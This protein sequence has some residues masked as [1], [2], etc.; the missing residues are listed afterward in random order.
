MKTAYEFF[1]LLE[2]AVFERATRETLGQTIDYAWQYAPRAGSDLQGEW[3]GTVSSRLWP[4]S[5]LRLAVRIA[6][7]TAGEFRAELDDEAEAMNCQP[8]SV[9]YSRPGVELALQSGA[10]RFR[11]EI[12]RDRTKLTG[13]WIQNGRATRAVFERVP[14]P[15]AGEERL[16]RER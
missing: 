9:R 13:Q 16:A 1:A 15:A 8:L 7:G 11:G 12:S 14:P 4:F 10:G 2:A 3:T 6:E 5:P